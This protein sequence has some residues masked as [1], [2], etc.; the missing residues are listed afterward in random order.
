MHADVHLQIHQ[1]HATE[2]HREAAAT[3]RSRT[4]PHPSAPA[5]RV[6]LGWK[7]VET[8]LRLVTAADRPVTLAA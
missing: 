7:L 1:L 2:L 3:A 8:G 6:R 5:F 4:T